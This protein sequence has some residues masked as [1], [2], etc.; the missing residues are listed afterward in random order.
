LTTSPRNDPTRTLT[1][2]ELKQF[3]SETLAGSVTVRRRPAS[4]GTVRRLLVSQGLFLEVRE[5][6]LSASWVFR[7]SYE[8]VKASRGFGRWPGVGLAEAS[9]KAA[10]ARILLAKG[11]SPIED[12]RRLL[13]AAKQRHTHTVADAVREWLKGDAENLTSPKYAAQ[14]GRRLREVLAYRRPPDVSPLGDMPVASVR[15]LDITGSMAVFLR[16]GRDARDTYRKVIS[17]LEKAFAWARGTGWREDANPCE[18]VIGTVRKPTKLGHRAPGIV[19][20]GDI[21]RGLRAGQSSE[22]FDYDTR[23]ALLL[24]LTGART[25]EVRLATWQEVINLDGEAARIEVPADRMKKRKAWTIPLSA[26]AVGLLQELREN[27]AACG[28]G[29]PLVF[30]KYRK[31]GRGVVSN[32][33]A[34][35]VVLRK[36]GLHAKVVGHG[37]R[38]LF[39]TAAYSL[40]PYR[41]NNRERAIEHS[42]AHVNSE[43]VEETYN[44]SEFLPERLLLL[45]WWAD[46]LDHVAAGETAGK[47]LEFRQVLAG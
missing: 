16:D 21:V 1:V 34:V 5:R 46:H 28:N 10:D 17:D 38:K 33:N 6:T 44:M 15:T 18:G 32:E 9:R 7:Y 47:V 4:Q 43:T 35:N 25:S 37:F 8:G 23:L 45:Q 19:D 42:L 2:S 14:K 30:Y 36:A 31:T 39:S 24:L 20:L 27:A 3:V 40:W 41:G 29:S 12:K 11:V 22:A 13:Q 26:Q